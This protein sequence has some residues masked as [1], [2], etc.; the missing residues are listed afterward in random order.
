[1]SAT[2]HP[3]KP[4]R[5]PSLD[6]LLELVAEDMNGVNAVILERMQS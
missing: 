2:V 3:L 6:A 5:E 1:M 4:V